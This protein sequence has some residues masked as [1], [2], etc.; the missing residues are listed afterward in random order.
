MNRNVAELFILSEVQVKEDATIAMINVVV[1]LRWRK[2]PR[3]WRWVPELIEAD[4][5]GQ[6]SPRCREHSF[7]FLTNNFNSKKF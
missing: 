5:W 4:G 7:N 3:S 6:V 2:C 1:G